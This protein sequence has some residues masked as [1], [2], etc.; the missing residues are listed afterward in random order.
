MTIRACVVTDPGK[1]RTVNEDGYCCDVA[2]GL[3]AVADGMGGRAAGEVASRTSI[4]VLT[5]FFATDPTPSPDSSWL[6]LLSQ[7]VQRCNT[8]LLENA[9]SRADHEG[10]GT[11]MTACL[12][13]G[14]TVHIAHIGDSRVYLVRGDSI[15]QLTQDHTLANMLLID[16][17]I[18][19]SQAQR[20]PYGKTLIRVLGSAPQAEIDL[21]TE[22]MEKEDLLL[23][24]TDGLSRYASDQAILDVCRLPLA[25]EDR[26]KRLVQTA[27]EAGGEDNVTV[28][29][30][31]APSSARPWRSSPGFIREKV[32]KALGLP[33]GE[34]F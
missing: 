2:R 5:G 15:R 17:Q 26:C 31:E 22:R 19:E 3:F 1:R 20:H 7:A 24:C 10:M 34:R 33:G 23:L 32:R 29:L 9:E 11:T 30:V 14:D 4:E 8:V 13:R 25:G 12:I 27:L 6:D 16:G 28:I 18:T 21:L